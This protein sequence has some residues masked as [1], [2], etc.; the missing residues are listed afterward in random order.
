MLRHLGFFLGVLILKLS[1][2]TSLS[3]AQKDVKQDSLKVIVLPEVNVQA[4]VKELSSLERQRYWR[5]IRDVKKVLP[6]ARYIT[7]VLVETYEYLDTLPEDEREN[8]L[9]RVKNDMQKYFD[10]LMRKLTVKQ[11]QLLM[12]LIHRESGTISYEL[13]KVFVGGFKAFWWQAFAR[14]IGTDLKSPYNPK[15]NPDDA[16]TERIVLLKDR[17]SL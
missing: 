5:R 3:F 17:H 6:Y 8:H 12:K 15:K 14:V 16:L 11:G 13:V 10:P 4:N 7:S 9:D 2:F 1:F